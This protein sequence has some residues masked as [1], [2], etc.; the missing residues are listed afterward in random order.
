LWDVNGIV[1]SESMPTGSTVD[2]EHSL[3]RW[4][5]WRH[6]FRVHPFKRQVFLQHDSE[7]RTNKCIRRLTS[8]M[9]LDNASYSPDMAPS[10]FPSL[11]ETEG[12]LWGI[13]HSKVSEPF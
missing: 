1:H 11:P 3:E 7:R 10:Q 4:E 12:N 8:L 13:P 5:D 9:S 6:V 2:A